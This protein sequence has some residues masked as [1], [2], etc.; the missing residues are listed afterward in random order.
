VLHSLFLVLILCNSHCR[1]GAAGPS[2]GCVWGTSAPG[3]LWEQTAEGDKSPV[4]QQM[5]SSGKK[6]T[7]TGCAPGWSPAQPRCQSQGPC[8]AVGTRGA[9]SALEQQDPLWDFPVGSGKRLTW[10]P[11]ERRQL[12]LVP[13]RKIPF[14]NSPSLTAGAP[15]RGGSWEATGLPAQPES[16]L[17]GKAKKTPLYDHL[18]ALLL[19]SPAPG[20]ALQPLGVSS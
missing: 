5:L 14:W 2:R 17:L 12:A 15:R 18:A 10:E 6:G 1:A 19:L 4:S 3:E 8:S 13:R 16:W 20:I 7:P 11:G 9:V